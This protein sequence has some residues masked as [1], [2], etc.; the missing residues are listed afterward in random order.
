MMS[1]VY[2]ISDCHFGHRNILKYRDRFSTI[3]SHDQFIMGNIAKTLR[4]RD[5]LWMLGDCFFTKESLEYLRIIKTQCLH[6][7]L[8]LG[9]HDT[10][11]SEGRANIGVMINE[12][13]IN[14]VGGMFKAKGKRWMTHCPIHPDEL[15]GCTNIH[16]HV[17]N[18]TI[19]DPRY[20]NASCENINYTPIL[21]KDCVYKE[22][23]KVSDE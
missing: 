23:R 5:V 12:G 6:V 11:S 21:I 10:D 22:V 1:N 7:N 20:F 15:R 3:E 17:H 18:S 2:V 14:K 19:E 4:K 8:V 13:L 9:N 16:G